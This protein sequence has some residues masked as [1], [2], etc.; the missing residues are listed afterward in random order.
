M[1]ATCSLFYEKGLVQDDFSG[2]NRRHATRIVLSSG[3]SFFVSCFQDCLFRT[4]SSDFF[5]LTDLQQALASARESVVGSGKST[6]DGA[7]RGEMPL[8]SSPPVFSTSVT[9]VVWSSSFC[10][11]LIGSKGLVC[12]R[13]NCPVALHQRNLVKGLSEGDLLIP[14]PGQSRLYLEPRLHLPDYPEVLG[15]FL[16]EPRPGGEIRR[17]ITLVQSIEYSELLDLVDSAELEEFLSSGTTV[18]FTPRKVSKSVKKGRPF[19]AILED[20]AEVECES[21]SPGSLR[22]DLDQMGDVLSSLRV[23]ASPSL[24]DPSLFLTSEW[25]KL[26]EVLF[27]MKSLL[28]R[29]QSSHKDDQATLSSGL[30]TLVLDLDKKVSSLSSVIGHFDKSDSALEDYGI[31]VSSALGSLALCVKRIQQ[32]IGYDL[33]DESPSKRRKLSARMGEVE[34][35]VKKDVVPGLKFLLS[36]LGAIKQGTPAREG[37]SM[38]IDSEGLEDIVDNLR[39]E[40][41]DVVKEVSSIRDGLY[42]VETA[43]GGPSKETA[44]SFKIGGFSFRDLEEAKSFIARAGPLGKKVGGYYDAFSLACLVTWTSKVMEDKAKQRSDLKKANL[45]TSPHELA[46]LFSFG[47]DRP[48]LV[49]LVDEIQSAE[50]VLPKVPTYKKWTDTEPHAVTVMSQYTKAETS[51]TKHLTTIGYKVERDPLLQDS[52]KVADNMLLLSKKFNVELDK[53][54]AAFLK[55]LTAEHLGTSEKE[56]W[57]LISEMLSAVYEEIYKSRTSL[58]TELVDEEDELER[59]GLALYG[60]FLGHQKMNEIITLGFTK[61]PCVVPA[62]SLHL[63]SRKASSSTVVELRKQVSELTEKVKKAE[64]AASKSVP[65]SEFDRVKLALEKKITELG[66]SSG[67][68]S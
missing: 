59:A 4:M 38:A 30:E 33:D 45:P 13:T 19:S 54:I 32:D 61:H 9:P 8:P 51:A 67:N 66:K 43:P 53:Q 58:G 16:S 7:L 57:A 47:C 62:L 49:G 26:Q 24:E 34:D 41:G 35:I 46:V 68:R 48:P 31:T 28:G 42:K 50:V 56:A 5:G 3:F 2:C 44:T 14:A 11:G 64:D 65:R 60:T 12:S 18:A 22:K 6:G 52:K 10:G 1:D 55:V 17:L 20:L 21:V 23:P 15:S 40:V 37:Q 39:A 27:S 29:V 36:E 63:F 25:P